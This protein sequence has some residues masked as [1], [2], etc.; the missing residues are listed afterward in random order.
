MTNN[1]ASG[2][3]HLKINRN[4]LREGTEAST[5]SHNAVRESATLS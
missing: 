3:F 4:V 2:P 5:Q 1:L